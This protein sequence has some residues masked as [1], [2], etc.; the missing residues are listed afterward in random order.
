MFRWNVPWREERDE[1]LM[2]SIRPF[3]CVA[4]VL[5]LSTRA[6][7]IEEKPVPPALEDIW[8]PAQT[9]KG[10]VS[11]KT[12]ETT[13]D[14]QRIDEDGY[15]VSRP[16]FSAEVKALEGKIIKVAGWMMPLESGDEQRHFVLLGYPPGCPFHMHAGPKQFVEVRTAI[17]IQTQMWDPIIIEGTLTLTGEDETGVFYQVADGQLRFD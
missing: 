1:G 6:L 5:S 2:L 10:G 4:V 8:Q 9:P 3:L 11:W 17:P 13:E 7:A 15:I 16:I 14:L 12:L